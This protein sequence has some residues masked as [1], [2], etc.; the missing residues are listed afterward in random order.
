M[1]YMVDNQHNYFKSAPDK[2]IVELK[3]LMVLSSFEISLLTF[4]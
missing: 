2:G 3:F 4:S 1:A